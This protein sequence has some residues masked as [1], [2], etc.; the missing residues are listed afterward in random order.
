MVT[1]KAPLIE[2]TPE[3]TRV[4]MFAPRAGV[5]IAIAIAVITVGDLLLGASLVAAVSDSA[6]ANIPA[7]IAIGLLG[8]VVEAGGLAF[9]LFVLGGREIIVVGPLRLTHRL[10][11]F[12]LGFTRSYDNPSNLRVRGIRLSGPQCFLVFAHARG[13]VRLGTGMTDAQ[14]AE[15]ADELR[16]R[17]DVLRPEGW[18]PP[19]P[20]IP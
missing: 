13:H 7:I 17:Y 10:E 6:A 15:V 1:Q 5:L 11:A 19:H 14:A 2:N 20:R 18:V 9:L 12:G 8:L 16:R 3:G 4:T